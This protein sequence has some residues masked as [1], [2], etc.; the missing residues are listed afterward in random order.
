MALPYWQAFLDLSRDR[1]TESISMG[2]AGGLPLQ[3]PVPR[4]TIRREGR[5]LGYRGADLEDFV[6]ILT[7]VDDFYVEVAV[8]RAVEDMRRSVDR[9]RSK[10]R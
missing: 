8:K 10:R 7:D 4:E 6:L 5:R 9:G 2:M 3:R 1:P